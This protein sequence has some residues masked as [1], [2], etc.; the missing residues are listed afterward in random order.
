MMPKCSVLTHTQARTQFK[1]E[2]TEVVQ[3]ERMAAS[4]HL[5][6]YCVDVLT[7]DVFKKV[8][9]SQQIY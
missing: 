3:Q 7:N 5:H 8:L 2:N 4:P 9:K 1:I 6:F